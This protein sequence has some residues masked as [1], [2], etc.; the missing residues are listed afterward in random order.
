MDYEDMEMNYP[1][2]RE[3]ITLAINSYSHL[4]P[5]GG[6]D[7]DKIL[8]LTE[9]ALGAGQEMSHIPGLNDAHEAWLGRLLHHKQLSNKGCVQKRRHYTTQKEQ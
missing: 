6:D 4:G 9:L 1:E 2:K 5:T 3:A 8:I 7:I